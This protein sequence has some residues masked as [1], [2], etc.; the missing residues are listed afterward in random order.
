MDIG[1]AVAGPQ[2]FRHMWVA[3]RRRTRLTELIV[4]THSVDDHF[5]ASNTKAIRLELE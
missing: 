2:M 4:V 5:Q 1:T 3:T